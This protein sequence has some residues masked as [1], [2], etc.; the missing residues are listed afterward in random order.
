MAG[1]GNILIRIGAEAGQAISEMG[2]VNQSLGDTMTTSEKM[3]AGLRKAALPAAAALGAIAVAGVGAAKAAME[4]AAAQEHLAGVLERAAGATDAQVAATEDWISKTAM[5]TGVADDELR[6]AL[7]KIV[8][9]TGDVTKAQ[10]LMGSALD[11]AAASGKSVDAV[12]VA[13]AKGY[14]GQ[15]AA[16]EKMIP[17]LSEAAKKSDDMNVIMGELATLTGGAAA[18][19]AGTAAG[20]FK[21]F[22]LQMAE[23]QE[24][25]GAALLPVIDALLPLLQRLGTLAAE[26]TGVVKV[27]V[28]AVA[29][30]SAGIL[31]ANG[32]LKAYAVFQMLFVTQTNGMT[33][34]QRALNLAMSMNPIGLVILAVTALGVA[35]VIA[36]QKSETF[37]NIVQA[38]LNA[39]KGAAQALA[40]AFQSVLGAAQSAFNWVTDHWKLGLFALGPIGAAIALLASNWDKVRAAAGQAA[41]VMA[42]A[43]RGVAS[44]V[45]SVISAVERLLGAISRIKIPHLPDLNPFTASVPAIA[46]LSANPRAGA[47]TS[48]AAPAIVINVTGAI[49]P[50]GTAR[51]IERV[52][53]GHNRRQGRL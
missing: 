37:R 6:P 9:A 34:A 11:I 4:D 20:Q 3:G 28:V 42:G 29:A 15:T 44:A 19:S 47:S 13:I 43:I 45:E 24:T 39:V 33:V 38:G 31:V 17:G 22:Q 52:L 41:D 51:A 53:R 49:D 46:G 27:L 25:L 5:A 32:V 26:N 30:L 1:P 35:L 36:Y 50:E 12:S 48:S 2:K 23:L 14:T 18:E 8:T 16:L 40:G 10:G 7:E 21:I